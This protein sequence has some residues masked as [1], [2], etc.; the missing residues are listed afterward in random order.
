MLIVRVQWT[1]AAHDA[2]TITLADGRWVTVPWPTETWY[3]P[4]VSAWLLDHAIAPESEPSPQPVLSDPDSYDRALR[5][6]G[7]VLA[8]WTGHTVAELKTAFLTAWNT[9]D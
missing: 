5:A 7:L 2:I 6:L 8:Y 9:L 4:F 1:D 3:A